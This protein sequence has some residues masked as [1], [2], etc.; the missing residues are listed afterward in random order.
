[1]DAHL[2]AL[3]E[4]NLIGAGL[5]PTVMCADAA[6]GY[7]DAAPFDRISSTVAVR[8]IP[9]AWITQA[10]PRGLVTTPFHTRSLPFGLL[11]LTVAEDRHS[12]AGRFCGG[13]SFMWMR[14][15][16]PD[17]TVHGTIGKESRRTSFAAV[18]PLWLADDLGARTAF[19]LRHP[20]L[21]YRRCW[22]AE[23]PQ[24][25]YRV[26]IGD[27]AGSLAVA[28]CREPYTVIQYGPRS[29]WDE[30]AAP[31]LS[32]WDL[33]GRP[34]LER[35]GITAHADGTHLAWFDDEDEPWPLV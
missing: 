24:D 21:T 18:P 26:R 19:G 10:R 14:A 29:L 9:A 25:T 27:R 30:A 16:R 3:C 13:V 8:R 2:A 28:F 15:H 17:P 33:Q 34:A 12:A 22:D 7:P 35:F 1:V 11:R 5:H 4:K 32:W 20:E 23:D 31:T 6:D